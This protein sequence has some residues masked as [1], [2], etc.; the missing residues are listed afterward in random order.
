M[1]RGSGKTR[2]SRRG[3]LSRCRHDD[4]ERAVDSRQS[5]KMLPFASSIRA[6]LGGFEFTIIGTADDCPAVCDRTERQ[7]PR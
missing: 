3:V 7:R 6:D 1:R 4:V 5:A 2:P